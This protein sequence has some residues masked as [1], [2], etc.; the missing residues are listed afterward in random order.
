MPDEV[1]PPECHLVAQRAIA[2]LKF[3][4]LAD[5]CERATQHVGVVRASDM[6]PIDR[7]LRLLLGR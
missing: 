3:A 2:L 5:D 7:A 6:A 1:F 4:H